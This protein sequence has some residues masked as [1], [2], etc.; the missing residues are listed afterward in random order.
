MNN[1]RMNAWQLSAL[2]VIPIFS[3]VLPLIF[4]FSIHD[5]F[6]LFFLTFATYI[7]SYISGGLV[8]RTLGK[9]AFKNIRRS[10][11]MMIGRALIFSFAF[12]IL[13][14]FVLTGGR[15]LFV[16]IEHSWYIDV[17]FLLTYMI[18]NIVLHI[19]LIIITRFLVH[20]D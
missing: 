4:Q 17:N 10:I 8:R 20:D 2:L 13:I 6:L 11:T 15:S 3:L 16:L 7:V 18:V 1:K 12:V 9:P 5:N 19:I 14:C